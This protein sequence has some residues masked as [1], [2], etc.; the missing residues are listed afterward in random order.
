MITDLDLCR[1]VAEFSQFALA[2]RGGLPAPAPAR[3]APE[4]KP[5]VATPESGVPV[6]KG[7]ALGGAVLVVGVLGL[8]ALMAVLALAYVLL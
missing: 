4:T 6:G 1:D 8:L 7:A 5:A 3:A 2:L